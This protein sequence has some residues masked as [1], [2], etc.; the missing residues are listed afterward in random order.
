[1]I[2]PRE[3]YDAVR[4]GVVVPEARPESPGVRQNLRH[5][6]R[7]HYSVVGSV[8]SLADQFII[9]NSFSQ[10]LSTFFLSLISQGANEGVKNGTICSFSIVWPY[11]KNTRNLIWNM[12]NINFFGGRFL[13]FICTCKCFDQDQAPF[14]KLHWNGNPTI[15]PPLSAVHWMKSFGSWPFFPAWSAASAKGPKMAPRRE[16]WLP[17]DRV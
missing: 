17:L 14:A 10:F 4:V 5:R 2:V 9:S 12:E 7:H 15:P 1:M 6:Q 3:R 16:I 11:W 13:K 8:R